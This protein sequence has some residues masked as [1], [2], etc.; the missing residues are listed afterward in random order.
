MAINGDLTPLG[1]DTRLLSSGHTAY[2]NVILTGDFNVNMAM[3]SGASDSLNLCINRNNLYLVPS[4]PTHHRIT[5]NRISHTW[6]DLFIIRDAANLL[7]YKK[8]DAPFIN[9][10]DF[11][12]MKLRFYKK[13]HIVKKIVSRKLS[14]VDRE[15]L[16]GTFSHKLDPFFSASLRARAQPSPT[17]PLSFL[18][19]FN[20]ECN[21]LSA[22]SMANAVS[23]ALVD[24]FGVHAP[25]R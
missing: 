24:A 3:K 12:E 22:N 21:I 7:S 17:E 11:I 25:K 15:R 20:A 5:E 4:Q 10:H 6:L 13:P 16:Y 9:V 2:A 18:S 23:K 8:S 1:G 14:S 19:N